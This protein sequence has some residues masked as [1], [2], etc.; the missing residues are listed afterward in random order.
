MPARVKFPKLNESERKRR[1][2]GEKSGER[3]G[4]RQQQ[5]RG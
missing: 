1:V 2:R 5:Q 3:G 4:G